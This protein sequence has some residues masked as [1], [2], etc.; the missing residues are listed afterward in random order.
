MSKTGQGL[1]GF[2]VICILLG[3]PL[4]KVSADESS[5]AS[6]GNKALISQGFSWFS[7]AATLP[8]DRHL[9]AQVIRMAASQTDGNGIWV[10]SPA[11]FGKPS[12]CSRS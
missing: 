11:G 9:Q 2:F 12:T 6:D 8:S 10:C 4:S 3:F 5:R 7:D 1:T